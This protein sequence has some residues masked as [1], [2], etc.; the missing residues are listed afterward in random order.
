MSS[1]ADAHPSPPM[2]ASKEQ[3]APL[4]IASMRTSSPPSPLPAFLRWSGPLLT[5]AYSA[6][7]ILHRCFSR[8][9]RAPLTT[10]CIG[11]LTVGG[12]G[13]T[14][15][16]RY[17]ARML[18]RLGRRPAVLM[19]GYKGQS[20]DEARETAEALASLNVPVLI[21]SDR[22]ANAC[23]ARDRGCDVVLLDDGFQHWRLARDLDIVLIDA[24]DPFGGN[25][26]LP[27][28]RL[29]EKPAALSRAQIVIITRTDMLPASQLSMLN[30]QI[31][32]YAPKAILARARHKPVRLMDCHTKKEQAIG[33]LN[34]MP[35]IAACGIGN[36][37]G[38]HRT[39]VQLGANVLDF[40]TYPDHYIY[41][42]EDL[43]NLN[44]RATE[45]AAHCI[46]VTEKDAVKLA[47]L[48]AASAIPLWCLA[49]EFEIVD[50][51]AAVNSRIEQALAESIPNAVRCAGDGSSL[52]EPKI[53]DI[54]S[55]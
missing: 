35:I 23:L 49:I 16:V 48:T 46:V 21:G 53:K 22:F 34:G 2:L 36:P 54:L 39:L 30:Q 14:P 32:A 52:L 9:R 45:R 4:E 40:V 24:L 13:K 3:S 10:L 27:L 1:S 5:H 47:A 12:T 55:L 15:A 28:G 25:Q 29:R 51:E 17:F 43:E 44:S 38:F 7:L 42:R 11:N 33:Q 37:Q 19:R 50:A 8:P 6:G 20:A 31:K 26:L 41:R 18:S